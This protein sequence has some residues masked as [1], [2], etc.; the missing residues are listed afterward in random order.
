MSNFMKVRPVGAEVF[1][2]DRKTDTHMTKLT[3]AFRTFANAPKYISMRLEIGTVVEHRIYDGTCVP[4]N[5]E[6][7]LLFNCP[8][9]YII[10]T[11]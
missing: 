8:L 6:T 10:P 11:S 1:H 3:V 4:Y 7:E 5:H 2:A 9:S